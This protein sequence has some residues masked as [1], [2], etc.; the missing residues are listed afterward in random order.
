MNPWIASAGVLTPVAAAAVLLWHRRGRNRTYAHLASGQADIPDRERLELDFGQLP[1]DAHSLA[2][3]FAAER[4]IR[5]DQFVSPAALTRLREE[6]LSGIPHMDHSF[7]PLH[8]QGRTL[9]YEHI[10]RRA[11]HLRPSITAAPRLTPRLRA[12]C[13]CPTLPTHNQF[14][15]RTRAHSLSCSASPSRT[16]SGGSPCCARYAMVHA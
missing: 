6:A 12:A 2:S 14:L 4:V 1:R 10:L 5:V 13:P 11:P 15:H 3:A 9:S 8:K 7:I 16:V